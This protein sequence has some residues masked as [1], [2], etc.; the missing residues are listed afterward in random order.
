MAKEIFSVTFKRDVTAASSN[1][2]S[3]ITK[4]V[5][6]HVCRNMAYTC[7]T[8]DCFA[9]EKE[10][11]VQFKRRNEMVVYFKEQDYLRRRIVLLQQG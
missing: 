7:H 2:E 11:K 8:L 5:V 9:N 1:S 10:R 3:C 6:Q 4:Y